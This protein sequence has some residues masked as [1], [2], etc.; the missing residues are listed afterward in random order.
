MNAIP[1]KHRPVIHPTAKANW[2]LSLLK[3]EYYH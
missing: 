3:S 2:S 1:P